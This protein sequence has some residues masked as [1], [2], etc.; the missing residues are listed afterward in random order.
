MY[1]SLAFDVTPKPLGIASNL[2]THQELRGT[3]G[4]IRS[5]YLDGHP[6]S[7]KS[8]LSI[9]ANDPVLRTLHAAPPRPSELPVF[10]KIVLEN[11][12]E[13]VAAYEMVKSV[14]EHNRASILVLY[15]DNA[16]DSD[17][18]DIIG[19]LT[20]LYLSPAGEAAIIDGSFTATAVRTEWLCAADEEP[21]ALYAWAIA[22]G[23][24][25]GRI[26]LARVAQYLSYDL[27]GGYTQYGYAATAAGQALMEKLEFVNAVPLLPA[28]RP[29][30]YVRWGRS[31]QHD[32][33]KTSARASTVTTQ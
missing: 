16:A 24:R 30:T 6:R 1:S 32:D 15:G 25:L 28:I 31:K 13:A 19:I 7:M 14:Y 9:L 8:L 11:V 33:A 17:R 5:N 29:G 10:Y 3:L 18:P 23:T 22:G 20:V 4:L 2:S 26:R 12:G 21:A 27:F